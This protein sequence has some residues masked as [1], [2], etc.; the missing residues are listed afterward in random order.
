MPVAIKNGT[1]MIAMMKLI[2]PSPSGAI[3]ALTTIPLASTLIRYV[4]RKKPRVAGRT[5][6]F[7]PLGEGRELERH[8]AKTGGVAFASINRNILPI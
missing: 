1:D 8:G 3:H 6:F 7:S 2:R 4:H 5:Q